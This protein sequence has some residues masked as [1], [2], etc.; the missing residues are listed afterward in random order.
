MTRICKL[1]KVLCQ[2]QGQAYLTLALAQ[3]VHQSGCFQLQVKEISTPKP[4]M[5]NVRKT[6]TACHSFRVE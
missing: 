6:S 4:K 5:V 3:I 1:D 2:D